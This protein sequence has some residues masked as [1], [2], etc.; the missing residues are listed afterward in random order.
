VLNFISHVI[1]RTYNK[2]VQEQ[3]AEKDIWAYI[4]GKKHYAGW[5]CMMMSFMICTTLKILQGLLDEGE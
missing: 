5:N 3:S 2:D 1:G 4:G